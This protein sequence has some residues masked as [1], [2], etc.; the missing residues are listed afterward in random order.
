MNQLV[1]VI[2]PAHNV[3]KYIGRCLDYI[4]S[5]TYRNIEIIIIEDSSTDKTN[6]ICKKYSEENENIILKHVENRSAGK[7]RN[8]GIELAKG[9][10]ITFVDSDDYIENNMIEILEEE[11]TEN[12]ASAAFCGYYE[13]GKD[14]K[15]IYKDGDKICVYNKE[16]VHNKILYT[17]IYAENRDTER[18]LYAVWGG[19][20][21]LEIIKKYNIKFLNEDKCYS[22]DSIFNFEFLCK[23]DKVVIVNEPLYNYNVENENSICNTY[24]KRF[25]Y[26]EKWKDT[27]IEIA[28]INNITD[29]KVLLRKLD[30]MYLDCIIASV[31]QEIL[32]TNNSFKEKKQNVAKIIKQPSVIKMLNNP[33]N[34]AGKSKNKKLILYMMKYRLLN[35]IYILVILRSKT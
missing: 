9:K 28:K 25:N 21:D 35:L 26:L 33:E 30:K 31:K 2:I 18:P 11:I 17:T 19:I 3:E 8:A 12:L 23:A 14:K 27:I 20:Y 16:K 13:D 7:S 34:F 32:A 22:E 4:L 6:A 24:N 5:Q 15:R 29:T 10:Y 1:S